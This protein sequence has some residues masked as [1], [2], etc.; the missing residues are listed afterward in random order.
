LAKIRKSELEQARMR[1]SRED[2]S[3]IIDALIA[4]GRIVV[5]PDD[6]VV[7]DEST[8]LEIELEGPLKDEDEQ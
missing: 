4:D 3:R 5:V 2:A 7:P 8:H 6:G 1:A